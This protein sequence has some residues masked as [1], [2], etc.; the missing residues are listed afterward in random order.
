MSGARTGK[1]TLEVSLKGFPPVN[2]K[3]DGGSLFD[4]VELDRGRS[5]EMAR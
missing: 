4:K 1:A 5:M 2:T 3:S